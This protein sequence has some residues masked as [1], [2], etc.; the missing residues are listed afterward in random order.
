MTRGRED[1]R[2]WIASCSPLRVGKRERI[3][4]LS[5]FILSADFQL[6]RVFSWRVGIPKSA[7]L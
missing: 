5:Q 6:E 3:V 4:D 7:K 2:E 1:L